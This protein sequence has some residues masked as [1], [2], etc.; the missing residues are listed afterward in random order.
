MEPAPPPAPPP[1]TPRRPLVPAAIGGAV[2]GSLAGALPGLAIALVVASLEHTPAPFA[3]AV[4]LAG[5][6]ASLGAGEWIASASP[7]EANGFRILGGLAAGIT[8]GVPALAT[9]L[10]TLQTTLV[11]WA[12]FSLPRVALA[13]GVV[14]AIGGIVGELLIG[15]TKAPTRPGWSSRAT[16]LAR[17][18]RGPLLLWFVP[19]ALIALAALEASRRVDPLG[20]AGFVAMPAVVVALLWLGLELGGRAGSRVQAWLEPE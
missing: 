7:R 5:A 13:L 10:A 17:A 4:G 12:A 9:V 18:L 15:S 3:I 16:R 11:E 2:Q 19:G 20:V 14:M 1:P 8:G 6:G